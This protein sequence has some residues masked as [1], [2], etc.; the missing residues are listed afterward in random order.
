MPV[1]VGLHGIR[2]GGWVKGVSNTEE[3]EGTHL[4][5]GSGLEQIAQ[6]LHCVEAFGHMRIIAVLTNKMSL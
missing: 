5:M 3:R 1:E 2:G 6:V 4:T